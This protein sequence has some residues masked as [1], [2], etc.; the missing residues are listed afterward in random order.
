MT[1]VD[2]QSTT[3]DLEITDS[4]EVEFLDGE[5]TQS[6]ITIDPN[7]A[8]KFTRDR[9]YIAVISADGSALADTNVIMSS[10]DAAKSSSGVTLANGETQ[11]LRFG[12]Y[13]MDNSGTTDYTQFFNTYSISAVA[14]VSYSY[15]DSATNDGDFRY[16][17]TSPTLTDAAYDS[18]TNVNYQT[19]SCLLYTSPSPRD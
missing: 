8:G 17:Q 5:I 3:V 6:L 14:E 2:V 10:R 11:G 1:D 19:Y 16:V 12:V 15:Q 9:S 13:S 4:N 18:N 7:S